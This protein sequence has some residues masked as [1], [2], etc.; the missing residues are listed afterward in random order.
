VSI[1]RAINNRLPQELIEN[2]FAYALGING[3]PSDPRVFS[4][5]ELEREDPSGEPVTEVMPK[6]EDV[7]R[8]SVWGHHYGMVGDPA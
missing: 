6:N 4:L 3:I 1:L 8:H 5:L 7:Y 2:I